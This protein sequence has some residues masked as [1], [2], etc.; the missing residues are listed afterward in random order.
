MGTR[1]RILD[2][3]AEILRTRGVVHATTKQIAK[4]SGLSEA[5]LY[6]YFSDKE[7]LLLHVLRERVPGMSQ[8]HIRPGE[9]EVEANLTAM[10]RAALDF[11]QRSLPMMGSLMSDP[12]RMAA[13]RQSMSRHGGGPDKA[14][15]WFA[16][17]LR[18]EQD[19]GRVSADADPDAAASLLL[20]ACFQ[21]AFLRYYAEGPDATP[22]PEETAR[23]LARMVS[24]ALS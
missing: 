9:A 19:L 12:Q 17:Y 20:G 1:E 5:A 7:E 21:Q 11:Y 8:L 16:G 6:K 23:A 3:A 4:A 15:S 2:S 10:A 22:A 14:V 13:H 24:R 18:A